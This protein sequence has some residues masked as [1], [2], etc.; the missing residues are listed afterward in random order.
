M[1]IGRKDRCKL[2]PI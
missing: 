2:E 1:P